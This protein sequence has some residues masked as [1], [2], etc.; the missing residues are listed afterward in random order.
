MQSGLVRL[1]PGGSAIPADS[2]WALLRERDPERALRQGLMQRLPSQWLSLHRSG[3][4]ALRFAFSQVAAKSGRDEIVVPA[5]CC[6]SIPA[7]A[8]A[9]GLRVRL[10]D[11]DLAGRIDRESLGALPLERA[12]GLVIGNLFGVPE[13]VSDALQIA[14]E[15]GVSVIDDAAQALGARSQE[16]PVGSRADF[17]VLSFG[18]SKPLSAL[19]GGALIWSQRPDPVPDELARQV[20]QDPAALAQRVGAIV[21][22]AAYDTARVPAV[23]RVLAAVPAL[24]IGATVYDPGFRQGP[25]EGASVALAAALLPQLER[26]NDSR[27]RRT[28]AVS[29]RLVAETRFRPVLARDDEI[30]IY[31]RLA[32]LAP[33]AAARNAALSG[34]GWLGVTGMYPNTLDRVAAL[35]PN[36]VG[37]SRCAGAHE[38]CSR[39]L[40]VPTHAGLRGRRLDELVAGLKQLS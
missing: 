11:V 16:G 12:A 28:H 32:V 15:A 18:R 27:A 20:A 3:R 14:R 26:T 25:I 17:G 24:G 40:T 33:D 22:A 8:V 30:G 39:L 36:L 9:A 23:L 13:P 21:R 7:A 29:E 31:P 6:Y 4:E 38:F 5:Y 10:V 2:I 37:E 19:G 1:P 35:A 34:F